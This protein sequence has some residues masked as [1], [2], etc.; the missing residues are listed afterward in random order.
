MATR[1]ILFCTDF[2]ENSIPARARSVEYANA[3]G[4]SLVILHVVNP[5]VP[6]YTTF[7]GMF[8][9]DLARM[10]RQ[11][12][13]DLEGQLDAVANE[14]RKEV[15][16]VKHCLRTGG[17]TAME[18][19]RCANEESVDLIV[20]GTHGW[21]GIKHLILGSTAENVVRSADCPVLTV[22]AASSD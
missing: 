14:C 22:R 5:V 8:Q 2:S 4:A 16:E 19:I 7:E 3:F 12:E 6:A 21:T 13:T 17:A 20:L 10:Q 9:L 18:I 11:L 1:K 15:G